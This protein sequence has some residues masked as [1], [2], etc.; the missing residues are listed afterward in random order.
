MGVVLNC[1]ITILLYHNGPSEEY[2]I[3]MDAREKAGQVQIL[4]NGTHSISVTDYLTPCEYNYLDW[5]I[6]IPNYGPDWTGHMY[7]NESVIILFLVNAVLWVLVVFISLSIVRY[8][9]I[10]KV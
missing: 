3:C 8:F 4:P 9:R 2:F 10:K 1:L 7:S 5:P 6:R